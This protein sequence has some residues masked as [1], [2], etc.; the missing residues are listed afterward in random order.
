[1]KQSIKYH[2]LSLAFA[3]LFLT[4]S[5]E[6]DFLNVADPLVMSTA[7]YP[8]TVGDLEPIVVDLY[9]RMMETYYGGTF[10]LWP[11]LSHERD[12]GYSGAQYDE[13][14]LN[15][16]NQ[17]L[18]NI[19]AI[20]ANSYEAIAKSNVFIS[21]VEKLRAKENLSDTDKEKLNQYEGQGRFFRAYS[22]FY[23]LNLFGQTPVRTAADLS[24]PGIPLWTELPSSIT[25]VAKARSTQGE[26]WDFIIEDLK[27]AETLLEGVEF[28]ESAR[29]NEWAV[30]SFLGKAYIFT[31]QWT[32]ASTVLKDVIDNSGKEL[33]SYD[34]LRSSF[35]GENEFNAE[36]IFELNSTWDLLGGT[37][38]QNTGNNWIRGIS[39]T[40]IKDDGTEVT[41]GF[42]NMFFHDMNIPRFGF[43]YAAFSKTEQQS[44]DYLNYSKQVRSDKS[45]DPRLFI[46]AFQPYVDSI[47]FEGKWKTI[48]KN[49]IESFNADAAKAWGVH[50]YSLTDRN[51]AY[52]A[53]AY[54]GINEVIIR[55]ADVYLLYA[56]SEMKLNHQDV[57]LEYINKVHRRAYDQPIDSPSPFDYTSLTD[58]TKTLDDT[59]PLAN[60][61]L[62]YERWAEFVGE[63]WWWFDV[64][65]FDLGEDEANYYKKVMG[66]P[67]E[68]AEYKYAMPIPTAEIDSNSE[69]VQNDG[70]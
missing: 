22:Y 35:N 16:V 41:N 66:G 57:A 46:A 19:R 15:N 60:D 31:L 37:T 52:A 5:C 45:V 30:K 55:L 59:D 27:A 12:H 43:D 48:G 62:K 23:L 39:I 63:G 61:V 54:T 1:M 53:G 50:K 42:G 25:S 11:L 34:I 58:R 56:E 33:V 14:A 9:G 51:Y 49:R 28:E 7:T 3:G 36:S 44:T 69:I 26:V 6:K 29:V 8:E 2:I 38:Q 13:F 17:N 40:Y 10:R 67:L 4:Y 65:R 18:S 20:W 68:W 32:E 21:S 64:R 24:A 47:L 70:Y